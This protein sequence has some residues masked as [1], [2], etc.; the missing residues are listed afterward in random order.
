MLQRTLMVLV[1][2]ASAAQALAQN[3]AEKVPLLRQTQ[4]W[5]TGCDNLRGCHALSAPNGEHGVQ[6]SS[7][8][9]HIQRRAG[10]DG[11]LE[12]RLDQRGE[13]AELSA[14]RLDGQPLEP[15]LLDALVL[16]PEK[17]GA[18]TQVTRYEIADPTR[19]RQWLERLRN[20]EELRLAGD[21]EARVPLSGLSAALLLM[22]AVQGR[23]DGVTALWRPGQRPASEVPARPLPARLRAYPGA[24][25][26]TAAERT[27]IS[28]A[29]AKLA[30]PGT[31]NDDEDSVAEPQVEVYP[32]TAQRA[33][34][35]VLSECAAYNC[36]Y[37]INSWSRS[38]PP[39]I[40]EL[41]RQTLPMDNADGSG[42]A[43]YDPKTGVLTTFYLARGIGDCGET[44]RWLFDGEGFQLSDY[45]QMPTC[46]GLPLEDWPRLWSIAPPANR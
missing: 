7:L 21:D 14:L 37:L 39:K 46:N 45:R 25:E 35:V 1:L 3:A 26:L 20:A 5:I 16:L 33:L 13:P 44:G 31:P 10:P 18:Q 15:Q 24:P 23:V 36:D 17:K 19:A 2:A 27:R 8:T 28:A 42:G 11:P 32:L 6:Y 30:A 4:E 29:A 22:D 38:N 41:R 12:I 43:H 40:E 9:L 34:T